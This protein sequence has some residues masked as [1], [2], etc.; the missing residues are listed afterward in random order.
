MTAANAAKTY[1]ASRRF[2]HEAAADTETLVDASYG[3]AIKQFQSGNG[4]GNGA[5]AKKL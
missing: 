2:R 1:E 5:A 4:S 3:F